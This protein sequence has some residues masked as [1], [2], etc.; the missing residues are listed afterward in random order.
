[1]FKEIIFPPQ[2]LVNSSSSCRFFNSI[3]S[4][5]LVIDIWKVISSCSKISFGASFTSEII[6]LLLD[7]DSKENCITEIGQEHCDE[8]EALCVGSLTS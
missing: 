1:M 4:L 8:E 6:L 2:I 7:E 3:D 5:V